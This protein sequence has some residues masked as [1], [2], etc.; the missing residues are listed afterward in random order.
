MNGITGTN[1]FDNFDK[2][3]LRPGDARTPRLMDV[4]KYPAS[5]DCHAT[6]EGVCAAHEVQR[7]IER[8]R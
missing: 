1:G 7:W 2:M 4:E 6:A 3:A 5:L 8:G